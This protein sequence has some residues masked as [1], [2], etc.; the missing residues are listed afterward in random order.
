M[1]SHA[2]KMALTVEEAEPLNLLLKVCVAFRIVTGVLDVCCVVSVQAQSKAT[3]VNISREAF[4][5]R[6]GKGEVGGSANNLLGLLFLFL[7]SYST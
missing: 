3:V 6:S 2:F 5:H 7:F 1:F 4:S